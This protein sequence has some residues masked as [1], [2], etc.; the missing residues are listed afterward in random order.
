MD[1]RQQACGRRTERTTG[2]G[3]RAAGLLSHASATYGHAANIARQPNE[4]KASVFK[5]LDKLN[6]E[7]LVRV[8]SRV[9][10]LTAEGCAVAARSLGRSQFIQAGL[11]DA[12]IDGATANQEACSTKYR[13][14]WREC[15]RIGAGQVFEEHQ[16]REFAATACLSK[17][18][19]NLVSAAD[20]LAP[21]L[22]A[23]TSFR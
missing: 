9:A 20:G 19:R 1:G 18:S 11:N 22:V 3:V 2:G 6:R 17:C 21:D 16:A 12:G 23:K 4:S 13:L 8:V 7:G 10:R 15:A 14:S 5:V